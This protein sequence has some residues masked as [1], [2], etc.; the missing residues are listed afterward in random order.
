[1]SP[2]G[3]RGGLVT[4][5]LARVPVGAFDDAIWSLDL[6]WSNTDL[7]GASL[8]FSPLFA[9]AAQRDSFHF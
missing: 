3:S 2:L 7:M 6:G 1:M 8:R 4:L 9:C 5:R